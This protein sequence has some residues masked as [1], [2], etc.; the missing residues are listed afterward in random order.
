MDES[1]ATSAAPE[2]TQLEAPEQSNPPEQV[3]PSV[4]VKKKFKYKADGA[5]IEEELDDS[6]IT[7]RLSLA[8]AAQ[9]RMQEAS[10]TKKQVESFIKALK[11][12]PMSVLSDPKIMGNEKFQEIAEAFLSKRLQ[13]QL[14]TPEERAQAEKDERLSKYEKAEKER[15]E[16]AEKAQAE[17]LE[18]KYR[19]Q[20][21]KTII[22]ALEASTL[23][24]TPFTVKRMAELMQ[25][26]IQ[27]GLDLEP[28][29][30]AQ[31]VK[32]DYQAE[33]QGV[34]G[35]ASP[36]Q[37]LAMF[38]EDIANKIRKHDLSRLQVKNPQPKQVD[39]PRQATETGRKM[40]PREYNEYLKAKFVK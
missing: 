32:E 14:L 31:L 18:A 28:A 22:G 1:T 37:L 24:K 33:L 12:D 17:Q 35:G 9:K 10:T 5:E 19:D 23:P 36:E 3:Q 6:E 40:T 15:A 16:A 2:S 30:L 8:K 29:Q 25:K 38:G 39:G 34:I 27:H 20:Y 13:E 21:E 26:N 11:D 4:P 7:N